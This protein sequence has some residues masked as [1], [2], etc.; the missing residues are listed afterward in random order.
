MSIDKKTASLHFFVPI[1]WKEE[2]EEM[3]KERNVS[4][5][6]MA[7]NVIGRGLHGMESQSKGD[8]ILDYLRENLRSDLMLIWGM[9]S[10]SHALAKNLQLKA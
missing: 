7:R 1:K 9:V 3:A 2:I 8:L 6:E 10:E 4:I 5:S